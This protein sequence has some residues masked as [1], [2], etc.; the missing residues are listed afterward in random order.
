M[1]I[2]EQ[3]NQAYRK[4][5]T[6]NLQNFESLQDWISESRDKAYK[7]KSSSSNKQKKV[8]NSKAKN[9]KICISQRA[10]VIRDNIFA[11]ESGK[12][13]AAFDIEKLEKDN[14]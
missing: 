12:Q 8:A 7:S 6:A 4:I 1:V 11:L 13:Y 10:L 14:K 2:E 5:S 3:S 9:E